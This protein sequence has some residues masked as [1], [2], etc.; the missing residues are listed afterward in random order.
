[1]KCSVRPKSELRRPS[2]KVGRCNV[3]RIATPKKL[4]KGGNG[5]T[6][7]KRSTR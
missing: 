1:M 3:S 2:K 7:A 4:G 6:S 5:T